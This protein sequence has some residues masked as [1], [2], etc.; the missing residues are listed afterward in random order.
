MAANNKVRSK[1]EK[2]VPRFQK[3]LFSHWLFKLYLLLFFNT[4]YTIATK[5]CKLL[6][7]YE[8][9]LFLNVIFNNWFDI[10]NQF[11]IVFGAISRS[12][13]CPNAKCNAYQ[14]ARTESKVCY[15]NVKYHQT[16]FKLLL[17]AIKYFKLNSSQ[18]NYIHYVM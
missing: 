14:A 15:F 10:H 7:N 13:G 12:F 6:F 9:L 11:Y 5:I 8:L 2:R 4:Y 18:V 17:F 1:S 16:N 3:A